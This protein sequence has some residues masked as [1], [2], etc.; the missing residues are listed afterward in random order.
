MNSR[1]KGNRGEDTA[2]IFLMNN[3]YRILNRN[4]RIRSGEIDIIALDD[5]CLVFLEVKAWNTFGS[6][7]LEYGIDLRK[8]KKIIAVSREFLMRNKRLDFDR[9]RYDVIFI[10]DS[11]DVIEHYK[12]AFTETGEL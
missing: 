2:T 11:G 5:K 8:Q 7:E 1:E 12:D 6:E 4:Y 9:I 10:T 3:G